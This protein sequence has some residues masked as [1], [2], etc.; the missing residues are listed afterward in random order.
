MPFMTLTEKDFFGREEE[1]PNLYRRA[2]DT[3]KGIAQ[4]I[5]LSGPRGIGK[6]EILKQLFIRLFWRQDEIVPFYYSVSNAILSAA[7]F[8][9]DFLIRFVSQRLAFEK[10]EQALLSLEAVSLRGLSS[11]AEARGALWARELLDRYGLSSAEPIDSLR[12]ALNA[13]LQSTLSTGKPVVVMIDEFQRLN[14]L[15][16]HDIADPGLVS[17]LEV[18][19][20]FK[21]AS[22]LIAGSDAEIR[23]MSLSGG[24]A[25]LT[26]QPLGPEEASSL[27]LSLLQA[28]GIA[29]D[30]TPHALV[31]HLGGNPFYLRCIATALRPN[32]TFGEEAFWSAYHYEIM[33]GRLYLYWSSLLKT[34]FPD[35]SRRKDALELLHKIYSSGATPPLQKASD[36]FLGSDANA[37]ALLGALHHAGFARGEFGVFR[38][39]EDRVLRD[40]I[41]CLYMK[42]ILGKS[43]RDIETELLARLSGTK[44]KGVSFEIAL[45]RLKESEL[46]A[47]RCFEQMGKN[48]HI[49][50]DMIGQI[51]MALIEACINAIEHGDGEDGNIH[52]V[53]SFMKDRVEVSVESPGREFIVRETGEPFTGQEHAE[54]PGRGW[55]I[56]LMKRFADSVRFEKTDRGTR[57]ILIKN[58]RRPEDIHKEGAANGE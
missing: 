41:D 34:F 4:N 31:H 42:E 24:F 19:L 43:S 45:P 11:L 53:L 2:L 48:L 51:Q 58:I 20:S 7:D 50:E 44:E 37:E 35:L 27:L 21:K 52:L 17:L 49:S 16:I 32:E 33:N 39:P 3:K 57:V 36:D 26:V 14:G 29:I 15:Q 1:L 18:P 54:T 38:A 56:K 47:A 22:H 55:G 23:E 13:P 12:I 10:K 25:K 8:S 46:V 30:A 9:R 5:F 40:F 6:T 28:R